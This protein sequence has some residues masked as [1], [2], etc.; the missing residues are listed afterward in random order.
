[1]NQ[2]DGCLAG[3]PLRNGAHVNPKTGHIHM[4]CTAKNYGAQPINV[5]PG[6]GIPEPDYSW[7]RRLVEEMRED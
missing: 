1:M 7:M 6:P 4:G 3:M 2:C 5:S